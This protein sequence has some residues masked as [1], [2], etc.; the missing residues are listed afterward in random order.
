MRNFIT[1]LILIVV[2]QS[3][4]YLQLQ[5]QFF[6]TWAKNHPLLMSMYLLKTFLSK[7]KVRSNHTSIKRNPLIN[8]KGFFVLK[9]FVYICEMKTT[10]GDIL[11]CSTG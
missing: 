11:I 1:A 3:L 6:W 2:G 5:S 7:R 8:F 4:A 10:K 9:I